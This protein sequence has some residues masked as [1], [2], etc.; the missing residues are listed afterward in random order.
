MNQQSAA[1]LEQLLRDN[2]LG[3]M[4]DRP[5][6]KDLA[7]SSLLQQLDKVG[8]EHS[9]RIQTNV[10]FTPQA[11][12][13]VAERNPHKIQAFLQALAITRSPE[14]LVMVWRI[15]QGLSIRKVE[16]NYQELD[17]F[18]LTI[19]LAPPRLGQAEEESYHSQDINDAALVRHFAITTIN[20]K[21]LFEGFFPLWKK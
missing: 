20:G 10:S 13:T 7:L 21:P 4:I 16:M 8:A 15:L 5:E 12:A 2:G 1:I 9:R 17:I 14:M 3:W 18:R 19:V 6:S 11:L